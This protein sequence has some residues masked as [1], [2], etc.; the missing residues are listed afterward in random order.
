MSTD[1]RTEGSKLRT[2]IRS[3]VVTGALVVG[4]HLPQNANASLILWTLSNATFNDGGAATG[5][6]LYDASTFTMTGFDVTTTAGTALAGNHYLDLDGVFP[7]YP[8]SGFAVTDP[9]APPLPAGASFIALNFQSALSGTGGTIGLLPGGEGFCLDSQCA[10]GD[11]RRSFNGGSVI[12]VQVPE[13][14]VLSL[15]ALGTAG[16]LFTRRRQLLRL[17]R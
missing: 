12:G 11:Y 2:L 17:T 3:L 16:L 13:P 4:M 6:F 10:F 8:A 15:L 7:P 1:F 14:S 5:H 9:A